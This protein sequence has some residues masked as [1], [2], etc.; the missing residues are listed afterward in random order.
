MKQ[1]CVALLLI[2]LAACAPETEAPRPAGIT[3]IA[4]RLLNEC[5]VVVISGKK[6]TLSF[7]REGERFVARK[8]A[9]EA[10]LTMEKLT[11]MEGK[12][13]HMTIANHSS[14]PVDSISVFPLYQFIG[15]ADDKLADAPTVRWFTGSNWFDAQYP[16]AAF[17]EN[18]RRFLSNNQCKSLVFT[19]H[20]ARQYVP[21]IQFSLQSGEERVGC[22]VL[23]EWSSKWTM[24]ARWTNHTIDKAPSH[25]DF[26][27]KSDWELKNL[28]L[29]PHETLHIPPVHMIYSK[30]AT[31][32]AFTNDVHKYVI[33]EI[34]PVLEN[35]VSTLP[36]SYDHWFG[37]QGDFDVNDMKRQADRA[38]EL[39][40]EYFTL[41]CGWAKD[42]WEGDYTVDARKFPNGVEE[43]A[44]HVRAKGMRFGIWSSVEFGK[45]M[46][47]F[48][49]PE[50]RELHWANLQRWLN[51]WGVQWMR[52]EGKSLPTGKDALKAQAGMDDVY[53]RL[54]RENPGF[55]VEGCE[56][57]GCRMDLNMIR[58]THGTWLNDHTGDP[59]V[60]RFSQTG[61]LRV[62][63]VRY[64]NMA[65]ETHHNTGDSK[66]AGHN[67]LSRMVGVMSFNGDIAQWSHEATAQAKHHVDIFKQTRE[68]KDQ[69]VYFPLPQPRNDREWDAVVFGDGT[70]DAQL[71]FVFRMEGARE[72]F[73]K[74][75]DAPG[76]WQ[77]LLDNGNATLKKHKDGYIV[78]LNRNS[79]ALWIRKSI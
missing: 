36:V 35:P 23:L 27:L 52:L 66:A 76:Q 41:D 61:A 43:L 53:G 13:W 5:P 25:A 48:W 65:I 28:T 49:K 73:L 62:W 40:C 59:D 70:G 42:P 58:K 15:I 9:F 45:D 4:E 75:P 12:R 21:M 37:I 77:L 60:T 6:D 39:G 54:I 8:G 67:L 57:G 1:I 63:P 68:Y 11:T 69:P 55:Y 2:G 38:A 34:A 29:D 74:I 79:S 20:S 51:D 26:L 64:L 44:A 24:G 50:V 33:S 56:G 46:T 72:Q 17:I 47:H 18:E 19:S 31:W 3:S 78:S 7:V 32:D 16:P 10:T 30:G 71:L 22:T 14:R